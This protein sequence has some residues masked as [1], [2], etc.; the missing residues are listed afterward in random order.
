MYTRSIF[1]SRHSAAFLR[2]SGECGAATS[3]CSLD[4][5]KRY[6]CTY[7]ASSSAYTG[8]KGSA[9]RSRT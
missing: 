9:V 8:S 1:T 2:L 3:G 4:T 7:D 5:S 6:S